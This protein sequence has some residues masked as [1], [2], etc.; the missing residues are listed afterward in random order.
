MPAI[1]YQVPPLL[2]DINVGVNN[3]FRDRK[4]NEVDGFTQLYHR[5]TEEF[6]NNPF[7]GFHNQAMA[8]ELVVSR[9]E[10]RDVARQK[11]MNLIFERYGLSKFDVVIRDKNGWIAHIE[12]T[13]L[14]TRVAAF[15]ELK[16]LNDPQNRVA[17]E[18]NSPIEIPDD[19]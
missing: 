11:A 17:V 10:N 7:A 4:G 19:E 5:A 12:E 8:N 15:P 18:D 2:F 1:L 6:K 13:I 16:P 3:R 9:I 14:W